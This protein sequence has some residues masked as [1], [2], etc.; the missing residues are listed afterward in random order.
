MPQHVLADIP[1]FAAARIDSKISDGPSNASY[2]LEHSGE[3]YVL[4]LDKPETIELGLNRNSENRI[5]RLVADAGLAPE[6]VYFDPAGGVYLRRY[7]P[8]RSWRP[9]DLAGSGKLRSLAGLLRV[10]HNLPRLGAAFKPL[11]AA[12]RYAAH[13]DSGPTQSIL[14][15]A[16]KL[17]QRIDKES[18]LPTLCHNDLVCQNVLE[19][20]TLMLID[21]EYAGIG[22]RFFDLAVVTRHHGLEKD[23]TEFF[24]D[25]YLGR[26]ASANESRQ[27]ELN[28]EFYQCLLELWNLRVS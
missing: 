18:P 15:E 4:R 6:P 8:G 14:L 9:S 16:E 24:L 28:S 10:L 25:A 3:Q 21:W 27:L 22:N 23:T 1:G 19:G 12:R 7:L 11:A 13:L 5:C 17:M 20:D 26:S 2:L